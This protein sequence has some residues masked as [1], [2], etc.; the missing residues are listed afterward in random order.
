MK[1]ELVKGSTKFD[2]AE[3][4]KMRTTLVK[5]VDPLHSSGIDLHD[6]IFRCTKTAGKVAYRIYAIK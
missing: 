1:L 6:I 4:F 2:R 5:A 3:F